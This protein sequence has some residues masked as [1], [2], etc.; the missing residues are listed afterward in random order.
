[1]AYV[2]LLEADLRSL[3][4]SW[5]V[6][7]WLALTFLFALVLV[8]SAPGDGLAASEALANLLATY[9]L[10][11]STFVIVVSAGAVSSEAGVLAD[12]ILSKAVTR[13]DYLLAKESAR[14]LAVIAIYLVVVLPATYL[15]AR[16]AV[17]DDLSARG[18]VWAL[19]VVAAILFLLTTVGV[20]FSTLFNRTLV[21][22]AVVWLLWYGASTIFAL[23][24]VAYLSPLSVVDGL[25]A[26]IQGDYAVKEQWRLLAGFTLPSL[27]FLLAAVIYF[28]RKDL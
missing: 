3:A 20:A 2:T 12:S 18:V 10:V 8:L 27:L 7:I 24:E 14:V 4:R 11:W 15:V 19:A 22:V 13:Y 28:A 6:R 17:V 25:P 26:V 23:L 21:A 1:M 9:P 5:V 16:Y